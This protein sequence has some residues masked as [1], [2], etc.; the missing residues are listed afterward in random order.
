MGDGAAAAEGERRGAAAR[1]L[2][3]HCCL[4]ALDLQDRPAPGLR[5]ST[6]R[7]PDGGRLGERALARKLARAL[8]SARTP[9]G[10]AAPGVP[11]RSPQ[12]C[13]LLLTAAAAGHVELAEVLLQHG[14]REQMQRELL[15]RGGSAE[16]TAQL[17]ERSSCSVDVLARTAP[18]E[19]ETALHLAARGGHREV[20]ELLL[21]RTPLQLHGEPAKSGEGRTPVDLAP[22]ELQK[23]LAD[24]HIELLLGRYK[25]ARRQA[26]P[27]TLTLTLTPTLTLTLTLTS[28][29]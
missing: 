27:N 22:A 23:H 18:P 5:A 12:C 24:L 8:F 4:P 15:R 1:E 16:H 29:A 3:Y 19:Q 11:A 17:A 14:Q 7:I 9:E 28:W 10:E 13:P 2:L 20:C 21:A 25:V 26:N 6:P